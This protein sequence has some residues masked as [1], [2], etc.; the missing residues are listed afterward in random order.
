[1]MEGWKETARNYITPLL[2]HCSA[3][4]RAMS[5]SG[6]ASYGDFASCACGACAWQF[7]LCVFF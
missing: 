7:S 3:S 2:Q 4:L 5:C 6:D 1:V